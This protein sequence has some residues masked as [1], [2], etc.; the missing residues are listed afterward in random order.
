M[1][2][3]FLLTAALCGALGVG[4]GAFGAHGLAGTLAANGREATFDTAVLYHL[5]HTL[6]LL[7]AAWVSTLPGAQP[8]YVRLA[9]W[10]FTAGIV[11][12][13]GSLYV[14][15]VFNLGFM[16]AVAPFGGAALIGGWLLLGAAVWR[17]V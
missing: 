11:L 7:G 8:R 4:L 9:G 12:F 10:L 15:A 2:R 3:T 13:S 14:L 5:I 1:Q 17:G 16:G 6:A